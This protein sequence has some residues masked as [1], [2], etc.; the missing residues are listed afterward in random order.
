MEW[1]NLA[2]YVASGAAVVIA[3]IG[4]TIVEPWSTAYLKKSEAEAAHFKTLGEH[5]QAIDKAILVLCE[6]TAKQTPIL[7][8]I[9]ARTQEQTNTLKDMG[10]ENKKLCR[11][12]LTEE[13]LNEM[14]AYLAALKQQG[15]ETASELLAKAEMAK[16]T[17]VLQ[18][19]E[20]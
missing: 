17:L 11:A 15:S 9:N 19:K 4:K 12:P 16:E 8:S 20:P 10:S 13:K 7:E 1:A 18:S 14:I 5:V 3:W 6:Q 2:W